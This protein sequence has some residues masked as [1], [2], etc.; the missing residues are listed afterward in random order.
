MQNKFKH[1]ASIL[2][3]GHRRTSARERTTLETAQI[4]S[5]P[6]A[7]LAMSNA[8][9]KGMWATLP[10]GHVGLTK[11]RAAA[12][13]TRNASPGR[14]AAQRKSRCG[15]PRAAATRS[16]TRCWQR[17]S[18]GNM[19]SAASAGK[20]EGEL[21]TTRAN[22]SSLESFLIMDRTE[23]A[24]PAPV[25]PAFSRHVSAPDRMSSSPSPARVGALSTEELSEEFVKG[26]QHATHPLDVF[27]VTAP[28]RIGSLLAEFRA[29][30]AERTATGPH[31]GPLS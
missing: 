16:S 3:H 5:A 2:F 25:P 28:S 14:A 31:N 1:I 9:L 17:T 8:A 10:Q 20:R 19:L 15:D 12:R 29:R 26:A 18:D 13:R 24:A 30:K 4:A 7:P 22:D 21:Q 6:H 23:H 11:E 27:Q